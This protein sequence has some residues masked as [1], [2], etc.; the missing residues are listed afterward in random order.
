MQKCLD[1]CAMHQPEVKCRALTTHSHKTTQYS[2]E[3]FPYSSVRYLVPFDNW[4]CM[5]IQPLTANFVTYLIVL[6]A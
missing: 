2:S 3:I 5:L 6:M 4:H 1:E